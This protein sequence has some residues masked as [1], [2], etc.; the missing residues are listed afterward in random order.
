MLKTYL[1]LTDFDTI[2]IV[3]ITIFNRQIEIDVR[4]KKSNQTLNGYMENIRSIDI[5]VVLIAQ[6][7][8]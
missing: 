4:E 5:Y 3:G 8:N 6:Q 2:Q 1:K 7:S